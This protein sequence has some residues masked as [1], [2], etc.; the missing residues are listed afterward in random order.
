MTTIIS[1]PRGDFK[2]H[3]RPATFLARGDVIQADNSWSMLDLRDR[4]GQ[5]VVVVNQNTKVI[6][7][8]TGR[9][10][11]LVVGKRRTER[12]LERVLDMRGPKNANMHYGSGSAAKDGYAT[13]AMKLAGL[14]IEVRKKKFLVVDTAMTGGGTGHGRHDVYPDGH[15]VTAVELDKNNQVKQGGLQVEFYQSGSFTCMVQVVDVVG[16]MEPTYAAFTPA[17]AKAA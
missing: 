7:V 14:G 12:A 17:E 5:Q 16:R 3:E 2:K 9:R 13:L 10:P 6:D 8:K 15:R 1:T 4:D 11:A